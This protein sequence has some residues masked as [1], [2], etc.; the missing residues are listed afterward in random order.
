MHLRAGR[1]SNAVG[2]PPGLMKPREPHAQTAH[3]KGLIITLFCQRP[4][5]SDL[6]CYIFLHLG[7]C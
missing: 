5:C 2:G 3:Q 4:E 6:K 1:P 7:H